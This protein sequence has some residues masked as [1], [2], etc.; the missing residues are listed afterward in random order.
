MSRDLHSP[1]L[2]AVDVGGMTRSSFLLRGALAAGAMYGAGAVGPFVS[3]ALAQGDEIGVFQ[4]ALGLERVEA[5]FYTASLK[6]AKLSGEVKKLATEFGKQEAEHVETLSQTIEMLGSKPEPAPKPKFDVTDEETFLRIAV[7]LEDT[8]VGAYNGAAPRLT[9]PDLVA[10][11][12][13]IVQVEARHA[14]SLRMKAGMD[15]APA[16]FDRALSPAQVDA[17][18]RRAVGG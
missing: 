4:F 8:G 3:R 16:P 5:A 17:A 6:S 14:A 15:P 13:G 11:A 12:G 1:E 18:V 10:A 2:A 7:Q 9:T